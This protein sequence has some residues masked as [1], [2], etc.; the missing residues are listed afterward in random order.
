MF[1]ISAELQQDRVQDEKIDLS[2]SQLVFSMLTQ[3]DEE[4]VRVSKPQV[5]NYSLSAKVIAS[6]RKEDELES[7]KIFFKNSNFKNQDLYNLSV[8]LNSKLL[9]NNQTY[10]CKQYYYYYDYDYEY[11]YEYY[12]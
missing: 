8:K 9:N 1:E 11:K 7:I 4:S 2:I 5:K 12:Y 10:Q 6:P 3:N